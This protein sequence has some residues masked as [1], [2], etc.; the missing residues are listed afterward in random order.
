ML[1]FHSSLCD[2]DSWGLK[3][4]TYNRHMPGRPATY[5]ERIGYLYDRDACGQG[6]T[7]YI[8]GMWS[9]FLFFVRLVA[10]QVLIAGPVRPR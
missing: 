8:L 1:H 3:C 9:S 10:T 5:E 4:L 6:V 7:M 2:D